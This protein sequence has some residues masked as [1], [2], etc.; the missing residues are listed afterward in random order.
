MRKNRGRG[1][2][3]R[4]KVSRKRSYR[5]S[6]K[7]RNPRRRTRVRSYLRKRRTKRRNPRRRSRSRRFTSRKRSYRK[8][9][10]NPFFGLFK[11]KGRK[12]SY[13]R[14]RAKSRR[15][16]KG[17]RRNPSFQSTFRG[18]FQAKRLLRGTG[19][20]VGLGAGAFA[21]QIVLNV[22]PAGQEWPARVYGLL[23]IMA[24]A[25]LNMNARQPFLKSMGTGIVSYGILDLLISNVKPLAEFLPQIAGPTFQF[26][27]PSGETGD[28]EGGMNYGRSTFGAQLQSGKEVEVVGANLQAGVA[29][30]IIG[31]YEDNDEYGLDNEL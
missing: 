24:G 14:G 25:M 13:K 5:R 8:K 16:Y 19:I 3:S 23:S 18:A 28:L 12:R 4:R 26:A 1:R 29:P 31:A 22:A 15:R 20:V 17:R 27:P 6:A 30:E 21:K 9:R 10:R 7:R 2:K 11:K